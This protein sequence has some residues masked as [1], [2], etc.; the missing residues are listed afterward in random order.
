MTEGYDESGTE[1][2]GRA[3]ASL[4]G[5]P[6]NTSN[7]ISPIG[8]IGSHA[9]AAAP[10]AITVC[11]QCV[12]M[13]RDARTPNGSVVLMARGQCNFSMFVLFYFPIT[14]RYYGREVSCPIS[15]HLTCLCVF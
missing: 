7:G 14:E 1:M 3:G 11:L 15:P 10:T 8:F 12:S 13:S 4:T 9:A 2:K 6:Q 5:T